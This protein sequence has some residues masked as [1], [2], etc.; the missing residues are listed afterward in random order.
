MEGDD[1][2]GPAAPACA[3]AG[4]ELAAGRAL[5]AIWIRNRGEILA[6]VDTVDDA[7]AHASA[8]AP[9]DGRRE[10][11]GRAAHKLAGSA[12]TFGFRAAGEIAARLEE[13]LSGCD[14]PSTDRYPPLAELVLALRRE[15]AP[16]GRDTS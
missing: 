2:A 16:G 1:L 7:V 10:R 6:A 3:A 4:S 5:E 13:A 12:G 11:A 8:G 15:L 14:P 9:D